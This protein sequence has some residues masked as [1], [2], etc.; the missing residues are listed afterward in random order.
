MNSYVKV[1]RAVGGEFAVRKLRDA[2]L[3]FVIAGG[4]LLAVCLWLTTISA[5]WWLLAAMV[6]VAEL[7]LVATWTLVY[8]VVRRF[9]PRETKDQKRAVRDFVDKL[10]RVTGN[11]GTPMFIIVFRVVRDII[12]PSKTTYI[13][14]VAND[15]T[16]L[17]KDLL[18][19]QKLFGDK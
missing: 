12:R 19:L 17:H 3:P 13:Q 16:T 11:V 5:W 14:T 2:A 6:L 9:R 4:I 1:V 10:E 8:L 18:A 15:S 7:L